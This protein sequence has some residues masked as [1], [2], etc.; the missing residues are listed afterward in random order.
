MFF[1]IIWK[2]WPRIEN[3]LC[4]VWIVQLESGVHGC[5]SWVT[6]LPTLRPVFQIHVA[7]FQLSFF[8]LQLGWTNY[9][10][11]VRRPNE[12]IQSA[13]FNGSF[14]RTGRFY[15]WDV[16]VG[17]VQFGTTII[18]IVV[19]R[20]ARPATAIDKTLIRVPYADLLCASCAIVKPLLR[21]CLQKPSPL[22]GMH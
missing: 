3:C 13:R 15:E 9:D 11:T 6:K 4:W 16:A 12:C 18:I 5:Y 19:S 14:L 21:Q 7:H 20:N 22:R 1:K 8:K 10:Y 17:D 2:I